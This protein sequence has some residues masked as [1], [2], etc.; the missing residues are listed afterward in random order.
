MVLGSKLILEEKYKAAKLPKVKL[1]NLDIA[2][3]K[4]VLY[5][6]DFGG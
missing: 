1:E 4:D 6:A 2:V 5:W 3:L